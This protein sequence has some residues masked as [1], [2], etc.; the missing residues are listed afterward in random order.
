VLSYLLRVREDGNRSRIGEKKCSRLITRQWTKSSIPLTL[1]AIYHRQN[2][3]EFIRSLF[4]YA[5]VCY[6]GIIFT[7]TK[8]PCYYTKD[9]SKGKAYVRSY[10]VSATNILNRDFLFLSHTH[11]TKTVDLKKTL[12]MCQS[13][14]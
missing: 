12:K 3:L 13:R 9:T 1:N 2:P 6:S 4:L 8:L 7:S 11:T 5:S 10:T 14:R